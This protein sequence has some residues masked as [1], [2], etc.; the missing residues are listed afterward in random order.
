LTAAV[1]LGGAKDPEHKPG[2]DPAAALLG[3]M[4]AL[5]GACLAIGLASPV[6]APVLQAAVQAWAPQAVFASPLAQLAPTGWISAVGAGLLVAV[7]LLFLILRAKSSSKEAQ[8]VLTWD[9]GYAKPTPR[10]QYTGSSLT[11]SLVKLFS[12]A[13]WPKQA[14]PTR[15]KIFASKWS[16]HRQVPDVVLDRFLM[17]LAR[18]VGKQLLR[19]HVFQSGQTHVYVLYVLVITIFL[20]AVAGFWRPS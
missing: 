1:F 4:A 6:L 12:F 7:G 3:P 13:L 17:P 2:R 9:C 16:F 11:D 18:F 15:R 10:M 5:A 19:V 8:R 20:F 14:P